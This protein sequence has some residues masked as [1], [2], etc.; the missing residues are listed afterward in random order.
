[1]LTGEFVFE[2]ANTCTISSKLIDLIS[3]F[4]IDV[5][6][7]NSYLQKIGVKEDGKFVFCRDEKED[8]THLFWKCR[9]TKT[10][11]DNFSIWLQPCQ[12]LQPGSYL[13]MTTALGLTPDSSSFKLHINLCFLIA[14]NFIW[15]CRSKEW[16]IIITK[17]LS[18]L[19]SRLLSL[20]TV[21]S[22]PPPPPT[23]MESLL[24]GC[25]RWIMKLNDHRNEFCHFLY[26]K[27]ALSRGPANNG[28]WA[29]SFWSAQDSVVEHI[30]RPCQGK[31]R[32]ATRPKK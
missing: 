14:K 23:Q 2:A 4:C 24:A 15:I 21:A 32:Q 11:W 31:F 7:L 10:F 1:M 17:S 26:T 9:K 20:A 28:I 25:L 30:R 18:I 29:E 8:L 22:D 12:I 27:R 16:A 19:H 3:D 13:D 5:Y 6:Q